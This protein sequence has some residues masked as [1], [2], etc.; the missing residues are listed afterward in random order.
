MFRKRTSQRNTTGCLYGRTTRFRL[1][2]LEDRRMLAGMDNLAP[3]ANAGVDVNGTAQISI[4]L[5][6]TQSFDP[7]ECPNPLTYLWST[8]DAAQIENSTSATP[9][10][11]ASVPGTYELTLTVSDGDMSSS[12]I[13]LIQVAANQ[14][15][16]ANARISDPV[17]DTRFRF[18]IDGSTSF[19][20]EMQSLTF[21][22][23]ILESP[24]GSE[25]DFAD[26]QAETALL[27]AD[28]PGD[29]LVQ[30]IVN[31]G[32]Q[33]SAPFQFPITF[34]K[35]DQSGGPYAVIAG[36]D[37]QLFGPTWVPVEGGE[38]SWTIQGE[39]S[40]RSLAN[41]NN[42]LVTW[43]DLESLLGSEPTGIYTLA[44]EVFIGSG[45]FSTASGTLTI[46]EPNDSHLGSNTPA[47]DAVF[48]DLDGDGD[49]DAVGRAVDQ[50]DS[51]LQVFIN[52]GE[53]TFSS[54]DAAP[55][56]SLSLA[57]AI[58]LADFDSDGDL[59]LII[60]PG[61]N[62]TTLLLNED[63]VFRSVDEFAVG[64]S[65]FGDVIATD[66]DFD[67]DTDVFVVDEGGIS[68]YLNDL[69]TLTFDQQLF[70]SDSVEDILL[71]PIV[72]VLPGDLDGDQIVDFIIERDNGSRDM[73]LSASQTMFPTGNYGQSS[74]DLSNLP[75]LR[76][77]HDTAVDLDN[78]GDGDLVSDSKVYLQDASGRFFDA[79]IDAAFS[80][81]AREIKGI[82]DFNQDGHVDLIGTLLGD[83]LTT[84]G[85][86]TS[87][88]LFL[89]DGLATF[90]D[91]V[92]L[93]I[94]IESAALR[95]TADI[96]VEDFNGDG[97]ADVFAPTVAGSDDGR[98]WF[99]QI[100]FSTW[101]NA[102]EPADVNKDGV[103]SP[104]DPLL[105]INE[106]DRG[107][108][109][110]G[111]GGLLPVPPPN[112]TQF[113]DVNN[114]GLFSPIDAIEAINEINSDAEPLLKG[115]PSVAVTGGLP[116]IVP[117][118]G[119]AMDGA[120][121]T[122]TATSDRPGLVSTTIPT[123]N[124]SLRI[125]VS[126]PGNGISGEMVFQLWEN[127]VPRI[128]N[129]V[130]ELAETGFYDGLKFHEIVDGDW[131]RGGDP[132]GDGTGG[133]A[134][135]D[136]DDQ[137]HPNLRHRQTGV[138]SMTRPYEDANNSQFLIT[139]GGR[140]S[141]ASL[142]DFD[143]SPFGLLVEGEEIRHAISSVPATPGGLPSHDVFMNDV[144][145][146]VD[147]QNGLLILNPTG[148]RQGI[149]NITVTA[150]SAG[151][152]VSRTFEVDVQLGGFTTEPYLE[153]IPTITTPVDTPVTY[154]L[155]GYRRFEHNTLA[156]IGP[157]EA[158]PIAGDFPVQLPPTDVSVTV[159]GSTGL[160]S[161]VP[162]NGY[163]GTFE[164]TVG[165][166]TFRPDDLQTITVVIG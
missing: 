107:R 5:D 109:N 51:Q 18:H 35:T 85:S 9:T 102:F 129:R 48:G 72:D 118:D 152:S 127:Y 75:A 148:G 112:V 76:T 65:V 74:A 116:Y 8:D 134:L 101:H 27:G 84:Q 71:G 111:A 28:T 121:I 20:P 93:D 153:D 12:D 80:E 23:S 25:A 31:D 124:R 87:L 68:L 49:L 89:N 97:Q 96:R 70:L 21:D 14:A 79:Q 59:D 77:F 44:A 104:V 150:T 159:D 135:P 16:F 162:T 119:F 142:S 22:W 45:A 82:G 157:E 106:L 156:F 128:T 131:I 78:D 56:E 103:I 105:V 160:L 132:L 86:D 54:R 69:G 58:A 91:D 36:Q 64:N 63:G 122:Y 151:R 39:T 138:I 110:D 42:A 60:T 95:N 67:G 139:D 99:N 6:G 165:L 83:P 140:S 62:P 30:L 164:V 90:I 155:V 52:D 133:S 143:Y 92:P 33:S 154:Q 166:G 161:I 7:D 57:T 81:Y 41:S 126:S 158:L 144:D 98:I 32:T 38:T 61:T 120:D 34:Q 10:F 149:A 15:P 55:G 117:L 50:P 123:G 163:T 137:Y 26:A 108:L 114:D 115:I 53:G 2:S 29:Y 145:V 1:E 73:W 40:T 94:S 37:L 4:V 17:A 13:M 24:P 136:I 141:R 19:D 146:I 47:A 88:R 46:I 130:I 125:G 147:N 3:V 66:A 113:V 43:E 11:T 100:V